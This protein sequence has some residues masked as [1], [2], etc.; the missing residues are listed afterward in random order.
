MSYE[1]H[2][3]YGIEWTDTR[4]VL[5]IDGSP[6]KTWRRG[7]NFQPSDAWPQTPMQLKLGVWSVSNGSAADPG[8]VRWA[9]GLPD[10]EGR[11]PF[12]AHF[13]SVDVDDYMGG[14]TRARDRGDV[15][16]R[17]DERTI[18]WRH[19][20]VDGCEERV[21]GADLVTVSASS[22]PGPGPTPTVEAGAGG[23]RQDEDD[24]A[25]LLKLSSPLA[26]IACLG[27]LLVL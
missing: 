5:S 3:T 7:D 15:R 10:W 17:Y 25:V 2:H 24:A 20:L 13:A 26:A 8:E 18:G 9:G 27:W 12:V 14:C 1:S 16:Y 6:R 21:P 23:H 11:A 4:L 19:V 22:A